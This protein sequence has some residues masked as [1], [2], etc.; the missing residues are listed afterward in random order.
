MGVLKRKITMKRIV[1]YNFI[2][3]FSCILTASQPV[4]QKE[5]LGTWMVDDTAIDAFL[6]E[7]R[8]HV[9]SDN[10]YNFEMLEKM[11][12]KL[13]GKMAVRFTDSELITINGARERRQPYEIIAIEGN[14]IKVSIKS[15]ERSILINDNY[16][17][18]EMEGK[19]V[20]FR[21][22]NAEE[23]TAFNNKIEAA[24]RGPPP[25]APAEHRFLWVIN[26]S[27]DKAQNYLDR[28]PDMLELRN[29]R[30]ETL[31]HKAATFNKITLAKML[32]EKGVDVN[33]I[34][35]YQQTP[36]II[37]YP[38]LKS[39]YELIDVLLES[40][41]TIDHRD[42]TG[43]TLLEK[44]ATHNN[45]EAIP[46]LIKKG[47]S[48]TNKALMACLR[49]S[50]IEMAKLLL[51][52]G[53]NLESNAMHIAA[54]YWSIEALQ[55][56]IDNGLDVNQTND[57]GSLPIDKVRWRDS[58]KLAAAQLLVKAGADI[59]SQ[60]ITEPLLIGAIR[61][62]DLETV[63]GLLE[64][65]AD[66]NVKSMQGKSALEMVQEQNNPALEK[67]FH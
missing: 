25:D 21:R 63:K 30:K 43:L 13:A 58:D 65:G 35:E 32:L 18:V 26:A 50:E 1:L 22:L 67:L 60:T 23:V 10:P 4:S 20:P 2:W 57:N 38:R 12:R 52:H 51:K 3:L 14:L 46:Y 31:L 62:Q 29:D 8:G 7:A 28:F 34:N 44:A 36:L 11:F 55:F 47:A 59:N 17:V 42:Y 9:D 48:P 45:P 37:I 54:G 15:Q 39:K 27:E 49:K 66:K 40:G 64:L 19:Q 16:M 24:K 5:I 53:A 6:S 33:A 41:A 61:D 56:V